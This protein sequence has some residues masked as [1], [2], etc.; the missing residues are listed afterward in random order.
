MTLGATSACAL[1]AACFVAVSPGDAHAAGE[2][3]TST[4]ADLTISSAPA[5]GLDAFHGTFGTAASAADAGLDNG[6]FSDPSGLQDHLTVEGA[7]TAKT[8]AEPSKNYAQAQAAGFT[9]ALTRP[10]FLSIGSLDSYVECVPP[11]VGPL[12]LAYAHTDSDD[13]DV[14]GHPVP[15]G[16]TQLDVTGEELGLAGT[17]RSATLT[18]TYDRFED[19]AGG[20]YQPVGS[21][22]AGLDVTITGTFTGTDGDVVYDGPLT[23]V[24]LGHVAVTCEGAAPTTGPNTTPPTTGPTTEPPTT[25]PTTEPPTTGPTTEPPTTEPTTEPPTTSPTTEPPTTGPTTQPPTTSPTTEPPTT[26]PTTQPPTTGPTPTDS[27]PP[28]DEPGTSPSPM[29][30]DWHS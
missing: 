3:A 25:S 5:L 4:L 24:E 9:L 28:T 11:P 1:A 29:D 10:D 22:R 26:G 27:C 21:A 8:D 17:I 7:L 6:D 18:V 20:V 23:H 14:V 30:S 15:E 2:V 13:I 12:A 19:P 16:T